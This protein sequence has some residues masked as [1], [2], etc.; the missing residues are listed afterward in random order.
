MNSVLNIKPSDL[1]ILK[2]GNK[3]YDNLTNGE[4]EEYNKIL[5]DVISTISNGGI[6]KRDYEEAKEIPLNI[7]LQMKRRAL[8]LSRREVSEITGISERII[9]AYESGEIK[10]PR[11]SFLVKLADLY[12]IP[13]SQLM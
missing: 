10:H 8:K 3:D 5:N 4:K 12:G 2:L 7:K 1:F 9:V 6:V 11:H 13:Y